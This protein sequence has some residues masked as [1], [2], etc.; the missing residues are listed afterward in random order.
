MA[1]A[2]G[3]AMA[4]GGGAWAQEAPKVQRE[5]WLC[6]GVVQTAPGEPLQPEERR[7]ELDF[8]TGNAQMSVAAN[9]YRARFRAG[10]VHYEAVFPV[11]LDGGIRATESVN[12]NRASGRLTA[13]VH[14]AEGK[15][16]RIYRSDCRPEEVPGQ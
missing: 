1:G 12:L 3:L 10:R 13:N 7:L 15:R 14:N 16:L 11:I 6:R 8:V 5:V 2:L 4:L 9:R